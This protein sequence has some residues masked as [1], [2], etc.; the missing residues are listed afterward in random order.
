MRLMGRNVCTHSLKSSYICIIVCS[1]HWHT[2]RDPFF[3]FA[4]LESDSQNFHINR[5]LNKS[6]AC[7]RWCFSLWSWPLAFPLMARCPLFES[8]MGVK[9]RT[10]SE[11]KMTA[12]W[13]A[14]KGISSSTP[15][16]MLF[17]E[18]TKLP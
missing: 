13:R 9:G 12:K 10:V 5:H 4:W 8:K 16:V 6:A 15:L 14:L 1:D 7:C 18:I 11:P 17:G 3:F 2:V